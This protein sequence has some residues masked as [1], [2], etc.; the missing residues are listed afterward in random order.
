MCRWAGY[1]GAPINFSDI[2]SAPEHS[3]VEQNR[4]ADEGKIA[5]KR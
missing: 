3:F 2:L 1:I 5:L 4:A